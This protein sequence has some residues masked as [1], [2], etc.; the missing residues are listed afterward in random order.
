MPLRGAAIGAFPPGK[1]MTAVPLVNPNEKGY[2]LLW[3]TKRT[4]GRPFTAGSR[5]AGDA[6]AQD[7]FPRANARLGHR[8]ADPAT[9][10]RRLRRKS[11]D[12]VSHAR[13]PTS[14]RDDHGRLADH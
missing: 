3:A 10:A 7:P 4:N 14:W 6:R 1:A 9:F 13:A 2:T 11:G 5:H 8:R 12:A